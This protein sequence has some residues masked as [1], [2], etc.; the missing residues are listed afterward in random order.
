MARL[1][2]PSKT[3]TYSVSNI[4]V[5][6]ERDKQPDFSENLMN[7]KSS[8]S[9]GYAGQRARDPPE[10]I[11]NSE[12]KPCSVSSVSVVFGHAKLEKLAPPLKMEGKY[13]KF[14]TDCSI[15]SLRGLKLS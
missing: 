6:P 7:F 11:P 5:A 10:P 9:M 15:E 13:S 2:P 12:V 14:I 8:K 4:Y 1:R 3:E